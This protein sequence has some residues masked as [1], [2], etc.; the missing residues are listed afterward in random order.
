[1]PRQLRS[2]REREPEY[3]D[4]PNLS[5]SSFGDRHDYHAHCVMCG[6]M[7]GLERF[8]EAPHEVDA[9]FHGYGGAVPQYWAEA[10]DRRQDA[11]RLM[12]AQVHAVAAYLREELGETDTSLGFAPQDQVDEEFEEEDF[13]EDK[14]EEEFEEEQEDDEDDED[15]IG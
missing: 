12:L 14:L 1:M 5:E 2:A 4:V 9:Y 8:T 15:D 7:A 6:M 3:R 13:E 11:L 10:P